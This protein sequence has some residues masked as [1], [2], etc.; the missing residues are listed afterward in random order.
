MQI[1]CLFCGRRD[2]A[3]FTYGGEA[4]ISRPTLEASDTQ[5]AEYLYFRDNT[6]GVHAERWCHTRGCGQWFHALRN[7]ATHE[8]LACYGLSDPRPQQ[9][10]AR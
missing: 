4:H 10:A 5:W 2:E 1:D 8:F 6:K 7:T 9:G 3:E